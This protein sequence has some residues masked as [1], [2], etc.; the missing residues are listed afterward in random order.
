[1]TTLV[2]GATGFLGSQ[3]CR[4]LAAAGEHVRALH[5]ATSDLSILSGVDVEWVK[6]DLLDRRSLVR[7]SRGCRSV[8]HCGGLVARWQDPEPMIASHV[9]GTTNILQ[10]AKLARVS[11][12]VHVSS[13][14][15]LGVPGSR[16][17]VEQ[18]APMTESHFWNYDP[19]RWPYGYAKH[20]TEMTVMQAVAA[21]LPAVIVNPSVVLGAGDV[22]RRQDSIVELI[23]GGKLPPLVPP[24]GL[25]AVHIDDVLD[26]I[27]A[28]HERGEPGERY[29]LGGENIS[30]LEFIDR[31]G[32]AIGVTRNYI[33]VPARIFHLAEHASGLIERFKILPV[34]ASLL[35]LAGMSFYYDTS[36]ARR[37]LGIMP[38]RS[39]EQAA[40][41]THNWFRD[42]HPTGSPG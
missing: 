28:V 2:T 26:G 20:L 21:G 41:A 4:R 1:M 22:H 40:I 6:G 15:A 37:E 18:P 7:A 31:I 14:A 19:V 11:R 34:Q 13:V 25:N 10:A 9:A 32:R 5:R 35:S 29:V 39:L 38:T 23:A 24:G 33:V 30:M 42:Q 12:F 17:G 27:L 16:Q 36:K 3:L 8:Y